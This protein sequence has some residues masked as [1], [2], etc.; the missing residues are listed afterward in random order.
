MNFNSSD[1]NIFNF[2]CHISFFL[3]PFE[4]LVVAPSPGWPAIAPI[5]FFCAYV[6]LPNAYKVSK[7]EVFLLLMIIILSLFGWVYSLNG[8]IIN[9]NISSDLI[10][11][12]ITMLL[13]FSFYKVF[14]YIVIYRRDDLFKDC[15]NQL[16][17]GSFVAL[18]ISFFILVLGYLLKIGPFLSLLSVI[19]KRNSDLE[20]FSFLFAE[21]S[22]VSVHLLGVLVPVLWYL[23]K[24]HFTQQYRQLGYVFL[25]Y[26]FFSLLFIA[27]ARFMIDLLVL[28]GLYSFFKLT[29]SLYILSNRKLILFLGAVFCG[30]Y[31]ISYSSEL[32]SYLTSDRV[33]L[34]SDF[35]SVVNSDASLASRFFRVD[36]VYQA[37]VDNNW[38]LFLGAGLGNVGYLVDL[39]FDQ[40]FSNFTSDYDKELIDIIFNGSGPNIFNM[41]M[42][43]IGEFGLPIFIFLCVMLY[44]KNLAFIYFV[45]FWCYIQFDSY[46]FYSIWIYLAFKKDILNDSTRKINAGLKLVKDSV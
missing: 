28:F 19:L 40:A 7:N 39:G 27:S 14:S 32:I 9:R 22:F 1:N 35:S 11:T 25:I 37:L 31:L 16:I 17:N 33:K 23:K 3:I 42:R 21:P 18:L 34:S 10:S 26:L 38:F 6:F 20:R 2:I 43:L 41:Y 13:G 5:L 29:N 24:Y 15:V 8:L 45:V 36:A 12:I 30:V 46:A 44:N 4:N